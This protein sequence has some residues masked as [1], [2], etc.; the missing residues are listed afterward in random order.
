MASIANGRIK[1]LT[2]GGNV[3]LQLEHEPLIVKE[4]KF[5][6]PQHHPNFGPLMA[7]VMACAINRTPISVAADADFSTSTYG[8][9]SFVVA[10]ALL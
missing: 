10:L 8:Q 6:I 2:I 9:I 5:L 3:L 7:L 1:S 4:N